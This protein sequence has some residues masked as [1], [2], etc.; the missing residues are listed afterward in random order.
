MRARLVAT[1][2][3]LTALATGT[4]PARAAL[5][6]N[7]PP[8]PPQLASM[9]QSAQVE[10]QQAAADTAALRAQPASPDILVESRRQLAIADADFRFRAAARTEQVVTYTVAV[11]SSVQSAVNA[12]LAAAEQIPL[13]A[14]VA[15]LRALWRAADIDDLH[16]IHV[17]YTGSFVDSAPVGDLLAYYRA[18]GAQYSIDWTFLAS[19]NFVESDFGRVN[20]PSSAGAMGPMQFMPTTWKDYGN[21][22]D[23]MSPHDSI[24]A[25][26]RYLHAMGGPGNMR[27]AIYRY[28]N[29]TDYVDSIQ[30]FAAAF[31]ADPTW[32]D[33]MYY[34]STAG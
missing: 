14:A 9:W 24:E 20:G 5:D 13:N 7:M 25:A 8:L 22:G 2:V 23:I 3:A 34:W 19:I 18:A 6:L 17:H 4:V 10:F 21:G 15:G 31:R 29:D 28:N 12:R 30:G 27:L 1:L 11:D 16:Q 33:R 32:V 26:A